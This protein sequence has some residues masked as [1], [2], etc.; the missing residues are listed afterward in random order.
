[1][2]KALVVL[3]AVLF[4]ISIAACGQQSAEPTTVET[5]A[6]EEPV[7]GGWSAADS[8][9]VTD[10]VKT[11]VEKA[12][13]QLDG[14][15]YTPVAY[16]A[17]QVVAGT[18]HLVLCEVAPVTPDAKA[19]YALVTIYEDLQGNAEI[20]AVYNSEAESLGNYQNPEATGAWAIP[21]SPVVTDEAKA[22]LEKAASALDGA[23]YAPV[24]LLGTQLVAG[25]NYCLLCRITPVTANPE[26]H[27]SVV[28]VY[29]DLE[30]NAE[31]TNICDFTAAA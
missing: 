24:A 22:A 27:Y 25:T 16:V 3:L 10:E 17:S 7:V 26:P 15:A 23:E 18:N 6:Q 28:T 29:A 12:A 5:Q 13:S 9:V 14:A 8:P 2:K 31:I 11:L 20:T 19:T 21:E 1:M 30:G 4:T